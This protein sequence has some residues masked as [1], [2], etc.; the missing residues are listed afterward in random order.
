MLFLMKGLSFYIVFICMRIDYYTE[1]PNVLFD[2]KH[3]N[4]LYL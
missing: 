3:K 1:I 2:Q 4:C